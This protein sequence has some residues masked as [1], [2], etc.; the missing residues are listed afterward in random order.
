MKYNWFVLQ[1]GREKE[2]YYALMY[3]PTPHSINRFLSHFDD[4]IVLAAH[5][6]IEEGTT[7]HLSDFLLSELAIE[8]MNKFLYEKVQPEASLFFQDESASLPP[9]EQPLESPISLSIEKSYEGFNTLVHVQFFDGLY[10]DSIRNQLYDIEKIP[11]KI[12]ERL[13]NSLRENIAQ[14]NHNLI[15]SNLK[16][17]FD[18]FSNVKVYFEQTNAKA[19]P[20]CDV[21]INCTHQISVRNFELIGAEKLDTLLELVSSNQLI[22]GVNSEFHD[23]D[24]PF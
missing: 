1:Y 9:D 6:L 8:E 24:L 16:E 20:I 11:R 18:L 15:S 23:K 19:I 10:Y 5:R 7:T 22:R 4:A 3:H 12:F 21:F 13:E 2:S 14:I 17:G